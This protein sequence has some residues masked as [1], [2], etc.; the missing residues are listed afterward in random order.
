M[1]KP[2]ITLDSSMSVASV[3]ERLAM[4]GFWL[5]P[6]QPAARDRIAS[7]VKRSHAIT[8]ESVAKKLASDARRYGAAI[9]RQIGTRVMWHPFEL[10]GV[11]ER[12]SGAAPE[13]QLGDVLEIDGVDAPPVIELSARGEVPLDVG[14]VM[15]SGVPVAVMLPAFLP[16][17]GIVLRSPGGGASLGAPSAAPVSRSA[18]PAASAEPVRD[19]RPWPRIDAPSFVRA[20]TPFEV[21]VGFGQAQQAGVAGGPV[22]LNTPDGVE[23][24]DLSVHL[25]GAGLEA[26]EGWVRPMRVD[27]RNVLAAE[28]RFKLTGSEPSDASLPN[29]TMLEVRYVLDS[30]VCGIAA[31]PLAVLHS[32]STREPDVSR[33]SNSWIG[34]RTANAFSLAKDDA[35]PDLTIEITKPDRNVNSGEYACQWY[36]PHALNTPC[37]PFPISLGH[38]ARTFTK[39]IVDEIA[40]FAQSELLET[41]LEGVGRLVAQRL[42]AALFEALREVSAKTA[43]QPPAVLIVSAEP[44][45]PWELAWVEPA[46]DEARPKFLGAQALVGRW[47]R[48]PDASIATDD[49]K[50]VRKPALHPC[51]TQSIGPMAVMAAWYKAASGLVRLRKSEA[52]VKALTEG[53]NGI[54]LSA[55]ARAVKELLSGN[56]RREAEHI[57]VADAVHF[58]GHGEFDPSRTDG[59]ALFLEDG[60]PLRSTMFR[61]TSF[62]NDR[63]PLLF[64]NACMLGIGGQLL[65]DMAG[66]PGSSLRGGFGGVIGALWEIED[67]AAHDIAL[68]FWK[69]ALPPPPAKGEPIGAILRDLRSKFAP[70]ADGAPPATYLAYVYYGHPRLTLERTP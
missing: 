42:P 1:F 18:A 55:T 32:E 59:S 7:L 60:T 15:E 20:G 10:H 28:V 38:D 8:A 34:S 64:L 68:E 50:A 16:E 35:A 57:G 9:R 21:V 30:V 70:V 40:L 26:P 29:L 31:R 52:E 33:R 51:A 54:A 12:C 14:V 5:S 47:L 62:G 63:Q 49:P 43:P 24:L 58:S 23:F 4:Q 27:L 2:A 25:S 39:E 37:G 56:L 48:E 19:L 13:L 22:I 66:F 17:S 11:L 61:A 69:R 41:T 3:L 65:G 45:I 44:Y 36:S 67:T 53:W 46:L 6:D